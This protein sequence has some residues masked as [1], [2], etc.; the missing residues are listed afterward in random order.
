[1]LSDTSAAAGCFLN[2]EKL[3]FR[4]GEGYCLLTYLSG[5]GVNHYEP[6]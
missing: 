5:N 6:L 4:M 1:M 2:L 3:P